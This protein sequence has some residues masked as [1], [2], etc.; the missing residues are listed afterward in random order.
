MLLA[1]KHFDLII[2]VD[3]HLVNIPPAVG[4]PMPHPFIG[5][6]FDPFD[7]L[8]FLGTQVHVNGMKRSNAATEHKL[9]IIKHI[10]MGAGFFP[11]SI[12]LIG[13][14]GVEFFGSKTVK[15][16]GSYFAGSP[17][18]SMTCSCIGLPLSA[19]FG[20]GL[21]RYLPISST[22]P[23]PAGKPVFVGGPQ[24]PDIMGSLMKLA[25]SGALS[26]LMKKVG[27]KLMK[28][29]GKKCNCPG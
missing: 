25:M 9:G 18:N 20:Q 7:Y 28:K 8:P 13:H 11:A 14:D 4:I 16:D 3:I 22:I 10:P 27:G 21:S 6:N 5:L 23:L 15:V 12:P 24:V 26:F 2:G 19:A 17:Y 1:S 29:F